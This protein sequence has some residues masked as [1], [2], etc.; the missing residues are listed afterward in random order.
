MRPNRVASDDDA[1]AV[2]I[3]ALSNP[4]SLCHD[5]FAEMRALNMTEIAVLPG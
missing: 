5:R 1:S 2:I 3:P 4:S